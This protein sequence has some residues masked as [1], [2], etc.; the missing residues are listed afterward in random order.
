MFRTRDKVK[1]KRDIFRWVETG[2]IRQLGAY[3][4]EGE[5]GEVVEIFD[6]YPG[7]YEKRLNAKVLVGN[8]T[9]TFRLTSIEKING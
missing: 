3:A 2:G 4:L 5:I 9:K 6:S 8:E 1:V 7:D